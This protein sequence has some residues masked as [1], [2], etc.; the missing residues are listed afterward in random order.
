MV[1]LESM[2]WK[3]S[4]GTARYVS[5]LDECVSKNSAEDLRKA[6]GIPD[7]KISMVIHQIPMAFCRSVF[8]QWY[9]YGSTSTKSYPINWVTVMRALGEVGLNDV[10][11]K[12]NTVLLK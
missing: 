7:N 12:V 4:D 5:V 8:Q 1:E 3:D 9:N 2:Y 11:K 6:L 10:A